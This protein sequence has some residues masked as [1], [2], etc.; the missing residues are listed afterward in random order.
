MSSH[1]DFETAI[2]NLDLSLFEQ[3]ESQSTDSDR[4]SLLACQLAVRELR[5]KY[6]YLEIG[7]YIGGS[8][9]PYLLAVRCERI[10][11]IDKRP[12][13]R[14]DERGIDYVYEHNSTER[15]LQNLAKVA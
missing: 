5:P 15:M 1:N 14:P 10:F 12:H 9:Q 11:S 13:S 3:I 6:N 2:A 8:I 7:S 4:A